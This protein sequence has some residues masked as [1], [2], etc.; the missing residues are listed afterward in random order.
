MPKHGPWVNALA[1]CA[2]CWLPSLGFYLL[3][4]D[5]LLS[6]F[7]TP[8]VLGHCIPLRWHI[9]SLGSFVFLVVLSLLCI[10]LS[11]SAVHGVLY[12]HAMQI[13]PSLYPSHSNLYYNGSLWIG[14]NTVTC[15]VAPHKY[16]MAV[17]RLN[18]IKMGLSGPKQCWHRLIWL[19]KG[20]YDDIVHVT[21]SNKDQEWQFAH[22]F[23]TC[24]VKT[25]NGLPGL[26]N[27]WNLFCK[28]FCY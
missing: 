27:G 12:I 11:G 15:C 10:D 5:Y 18:I 22:Y 20:L 25:G 6:M 13:Y 21:K 1:Y 28:G 2:L 9:V 4:Q 26:F 14:Y 19:L 16:L 24:S 7:I 3:N 17:G 8:H 23:V